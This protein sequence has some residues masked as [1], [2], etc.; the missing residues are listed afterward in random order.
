MTAQ[1]G[2]CLC[3]VRHLKK[4]SQRALCSVRVVA[5]GRAQD[6]FGGIQGR[7]LFK[8][9][10]QNQ[11]EEKEIYEAISCSYLDYLFFLY[12]WGERGTGQFSPLWDITPSSPAP[13]LQCQPWSPQK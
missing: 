2:V 8:I 1:C 7:S 4:N 11:S 12:F 9:F 5:I 6:F 10:F 3:Y 13:S